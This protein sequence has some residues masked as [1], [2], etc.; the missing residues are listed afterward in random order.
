MNKVILL[1][2]VSN[3]DTRKVGKDHL[4]TNL[5]IAIN[6]LKGEAEF[7]NVTLW[8]KKADFTEK[9][10]EKGKRVLIEGYLTK[11]KYTDKDGK[12][13]ELTKIVGTNIEFADGKTEKPDELP[14]K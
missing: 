14:F 12:T 7:F 6:N 2:R 10:I 5:G 13:M 8:D 1:G 11:E 9:Y 4:V 3:K